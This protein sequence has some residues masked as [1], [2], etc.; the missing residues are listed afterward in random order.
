MDQDAAIRATSVR[1]SYL[2]GRGLHTPMQGGLWGVKPLS[3]STYR[4][5]FDI[6]SLQ[7]RVLV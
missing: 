2:V 5:E 7:H 6:V 1:T 4:Y 3:Y